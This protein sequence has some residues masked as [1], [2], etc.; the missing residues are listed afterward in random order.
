MRPV[1]VTAALLLAVPALLA[2]CG[3]SASGPPATPEQVCTQMTNIAGTLKNLNTGIESGQAS[4]AAITSTTTQLKQ[5][6]VDL[7][8]AMADI[9]DPNAA[10]L[11]ASFRQ[12]QLAYTRLAPGTTPQE[13]QAELREPAADVKA[14]YLALV[15][16]LACPT[17]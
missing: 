14:S 2:G 3:G 9:D 17:P 1:I 12:Y 11:S 16:S 5:E 15:D 7:N 10:K 6:L 4:I 8:A 13:A